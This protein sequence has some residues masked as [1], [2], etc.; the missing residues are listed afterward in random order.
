M[1]ILI[2]GPYRSGTNDDQNLMARNLDQL[3]AAALPLLAKGHLPMIG[4]WITLPLINLAWGAQEI[5][6]AI[7]DD[8]WTRIQHPIA[9]QLL[10]RCDAVLRIGGA[11]VGA[12][13]DVKLA[14]DLGLPVYYRLEDVPIAE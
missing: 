3:Q 2:A 9:H 8:T 12:D 7:G 1:M 11:S 6:G 13:E 10:M 14:L 4:E 5:P